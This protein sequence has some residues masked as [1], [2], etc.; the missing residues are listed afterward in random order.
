MYSSFSDRFGPFCV[1]STI[2]TVRTGRN[3]IVSPLNPIRSRCISRAINYI[4]R[5]PARSKTNTLPSPRSMFGLI[6]IFRSTPWHA[7]SYVTFCS[8]FNVLLLPLPVLLIFHIHRRVINNVQLRLP[9]TD[10][11][12]QST[13]RF[14]SGGASPY[15]LPPCIVTV[16]NCVSVGD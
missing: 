4:V 3:V 8:L 6:N 1:R 7:T 2:R 9:N 14:N 13:D 10:Y 11:Y 12:L 16:L 15:R 5:P